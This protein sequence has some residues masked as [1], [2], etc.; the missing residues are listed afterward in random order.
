[1]ASPQ[2]NAATIRRGYELFNS[3]NLEE[4]APIFAE[5]V[6]WHAGGRGRFSGD[7]RGRDA[8]FAY[9]GQLAVVARRLRAHD[10]VEAACSL[11]AAVYRAP[12]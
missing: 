12:R 4:L 5:D 8:T 1:M 10:A 11:I 9:F 6:V 2:E 3:G 7:K